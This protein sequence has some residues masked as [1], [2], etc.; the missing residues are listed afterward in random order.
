MVTGCNNAG[1]AYDEIQRK[2]CFFK[3]TYNFRVFDC[4]DIL[5]AEIIENGETITRTETKTEGRLGR[6]IV[7]GVLFGGAGAVVGGLTGKSNSNSIS[8]NY[9]TQIDLKIIV[10]DTNNPV[11]IIRFL[12]TA[13]GKQSYLYK[14]AIEKAM[15]C[16]AIINVL[17]SQANEK[18]NASTIE[19]KEIAK[20]PPPKNNI[21]VSTE[22]YKLLELMNQG[23]ITEKEF[24]A[25]KKKLLA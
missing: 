1:I 6:A 12:Q 23:I 20:E 18:D 25:Q 16:H 10:K 17:I 4:Q 3:N 21:M 9:I 8:V 11:H 22:I 24:E 2:I 19:I 13:T 5:S 7:G 15:K 14:N